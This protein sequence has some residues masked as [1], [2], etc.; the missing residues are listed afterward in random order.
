MSLQVVTNLYVGYRIVYF[1]CYVNV[2]GFTGT[3][4]LL[5]AASKAISRTAVFGTLFRIFRGLMDKYITR[6]V[7]W[8]NWPFYSKPA[9]ISSH[10]VYIRCIAGFRAGSTSH[11]LSTSEQLRVDFALG[12]FFVLILGVKIDL[13]VMWVLYFIYSYTQR[14]DNQTDF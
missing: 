7:R 10:T 13:P 11:S 3:D 5:K 2:G 8:M 1:W 14:S 4:S 6:R 9:E 12:V